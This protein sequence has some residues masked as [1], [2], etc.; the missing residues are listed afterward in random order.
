MTTPL[1]LI[2]G[3]TGVG[4]SDLALDLAKRFDGEILNADSRQVYRH[5]HIGTGKPT[6]E[7]RAEVPHHLLDV[8]DPGEEFDVSRFCSL[9]HAEIQRIFER[10]RL[11]IVSGGTGLY[12]K[13]LTQ[14]IFRGPGR[15][16]S[17]RLK[18]TEEERQ[19]P[20]ALFERL[21]LIDPVLAHKVKPKDRMRIIR[22]LEVYETTGKRMSEWQRSH[23]FQERRYRT[24]KIG[25]V[26]PKSQLHGLIEDRCRKMFERGLIAEVESLRARG[27]AFDLKPLHT[28][29]YREVWL[30]LDGELS[31]DEAKQRMVRETKRFAK[32]QMTWFKKDPEIRWFHPQKD[33][34]EILASVKEFLEAH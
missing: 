17:I 33:R 10:R 26:R 19:K 20:G 23:G 16:E 12:V 3:A 34:Q 8:A 9:A 32:R 1:L 4:K 15:N 2:L 27:L 24:L 18:L 31:L 11:P 21:S 28:I 22:A 25:L 6:P 13:A 29:G 5:L 14:G 30:Y 7:E